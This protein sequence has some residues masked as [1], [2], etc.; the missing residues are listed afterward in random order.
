MG[1]DR[2]GTTPRLDGRLPLRDAWVWALTA[3]VDRAIAAA[4]A[5]VSDLRDAVHRQRRSLRAARAIVRLARPVLPA[6]ERA[7]LLVPLAA[8]MRATTALRDRAVV[9]E[10]VRQT[11]LADRLPPELEQLVAAD[12]DP[13]GDV[14]AV[15]AVLRRAAEQV[16]DVPEQFL[17]K[18][19]PGVEWLHV[20]RGLRASYRRAHRA[21]RAAVR[22]PADAVALHE[23]RKR[24]KELRDQIAL[25]GEGESSPLARPHR[26]LVELARALGDVTDRVVLCA[27]VEACGDRLPPELARAVALRLRTAIQRGRTH[28]LRDG[29][30]ILTDSARVV[31]TRWVDRIVP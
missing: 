10:L 14:A 3:S 31:A 8:G 27:Y 25:F 15:R 6:G 30:R 21:L 28:A 22:A 20:E 26:Q 11:S 9:A 23:L 24:V 4:G 16:A 18:L 1:T 17:T 2:H 29:R 19:L 7:D 12:K 13:Y 5:D